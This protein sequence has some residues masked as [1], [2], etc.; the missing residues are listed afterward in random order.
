[1][2]VVDVK[3]DT[4]STTAS[5]RAAIVIPQPERVKQWSE[6]PIVVVVVVVVIKGKEKRSG[7]ETDRET[8]NRTRRAVS[9][10]PVYYDVFGLAERGQLGL[11]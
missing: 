8:K 5:P 2:L 7:N 9:I 10:L 11:D 1:M 4:K 3:S 6:S